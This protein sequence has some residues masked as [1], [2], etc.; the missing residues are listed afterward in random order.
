MLV[1]AEFLTVLDGIDVLAPHILLMC[2]AH[3]IICADAAKIES[4]QPADRPLAGHD[5][6]IRAELTLL[7]PHL[8]AQAVNRQYR[9]AHPGL[10]RHEA[11]ALLG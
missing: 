7:F 6:A 9:I 4:F 11:A 2:I 10:K 1:A 8:A 3:E 5:D